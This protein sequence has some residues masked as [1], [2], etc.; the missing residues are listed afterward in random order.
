[1]GT[2]VPS[3]DQSMSTARITLPANLPPNAKP[4]DLVHVSRAS[5]TGRSS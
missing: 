2:G 1:M 4:V 5:R 3:G